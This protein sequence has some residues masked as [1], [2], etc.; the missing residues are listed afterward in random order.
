M[1]MILVKIFAW[2]IILLLGPAYR[3]DITNREKKAKSLYISLFISQK[4]GNGEQYEMM[5]WDH[6]DEDLAIVRY[7]VIFMMMGGGGQRQENCS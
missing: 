6:K 5:Q 1:L 4:V 3:K 7:L 2:G